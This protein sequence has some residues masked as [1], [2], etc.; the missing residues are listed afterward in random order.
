M[1]SPDVKFDD[2]CIECTVEIKHDTNHLPQHLPQHLRE[3]VAEKLMRWAQQKDDVLG[4]PAPTVGLPTPKYIY[5]DR[6]YSA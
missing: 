3:D 2:L 5:K 4:F 1:F 6:V